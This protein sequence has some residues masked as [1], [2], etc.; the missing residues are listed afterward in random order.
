MFTF[1]QYCIICKYNNVRTYIYSLNHI[2]VAPTKN[3]ASITGVRVSDS[4]MM[5]SWTGLTL[6]EARGFPSYTI[7]YEP[8]GSTGRVSRQA[9]TVQT[10]QT[11]TTVG[12]LLSEAEYLVHITVST[13]GGNSAASEPGMVLWQCIDVI[14]SL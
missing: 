8:V 7:T 13:D 12:G 6:Q 4:E 11:S 1:P 2:H 10:E 14:C 5:V 9:Q 3:V